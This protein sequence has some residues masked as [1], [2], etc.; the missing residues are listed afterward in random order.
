MKIPIPKGF[1][2]N[3]DS[4]N[5][6]ELLKMVADMVQQIQ[7]LEEDSIYNFEWAREQAHINENL[8][9]ENRMLKEENEQLKRGK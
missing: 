9:Q 2:E 4:V 7:K 8:K 1:F 5:Q 6:A 3:K